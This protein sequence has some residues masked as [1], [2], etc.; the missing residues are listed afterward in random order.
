MFT[1]KMI[2]DL[3]S[4]T[5]LIVQTGREV[6]FKLPKNTEP[7]YRIFPTCG[8][9]RSPFGSLSKWNLEMEIQ[10]YYVPHDSEKYTREH[11]EELYHRWN[12]EEAYIL[13]KE[14]D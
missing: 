9:H 2:G 11:S 13:L 7:N 1:L 5:L 3:R 12:E 6:G 10:R 14:Q 8:I 4:R